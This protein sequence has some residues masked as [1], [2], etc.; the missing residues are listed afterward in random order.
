MT[1]FKK[2]TPTMPLGLGAK[3]RFDN[4]VILAIDCGFHHVKT[5]YLDGISLLANPR[6][7]DTYFITAITIS[8]VFDGNMRLFNL[9]N[10]Q[11]PKF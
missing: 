11:C 5:D 2:I 3:Y 9:G 1:Q 10:V 8:K 6:R 7:N 4:N